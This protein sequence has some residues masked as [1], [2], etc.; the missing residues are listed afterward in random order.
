[1]IRFSTSV[2]DPAGTLYIHTNKY[3]HTQAAGLCLHFHLSIIRKGRGKTNNTT[4]QRDLKRDK[5]QREA[6]E[7]VTFFFSFLFSVIVCFRVRV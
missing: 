3:S 4:K 6:F 2:M 1:M 7:R 5:R